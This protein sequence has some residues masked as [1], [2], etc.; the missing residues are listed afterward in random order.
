MEPQLVLVDLV[1]ATDCR[2]NF[3]NGMEMMLSRMI[4]I[5]PDELRKMITGMVDAVHEGNQ[6][7]KRIEKMLMEER[8]GKFNGGQ[9]ELPSP[10]DSKHITL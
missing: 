4:G 10:S 3:M 7:M 9:Q 6:T 1:S 8:E 2:D 5:A